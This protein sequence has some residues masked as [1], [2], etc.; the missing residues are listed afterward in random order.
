MYAPPSPTNFI[1]Y[2]SIP[3]PWGR[4]SYGFQPDVILLVTSGRFP[5]FIMEGG[6]AQNPCGIYIIL[7]WRNMIIWGVTVCK[8]L[9]ENTLLLPTFFPHLIYVVILARCEFSSTCC[10]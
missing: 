10:V 7:V 9:D 8:D 1:S 6:W 4:R 5:L 2:G 3:V